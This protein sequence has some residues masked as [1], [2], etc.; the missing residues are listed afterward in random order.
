MAELGHSKFKSIDLRQQ[1]QEQRIQSFN[2]GYHA[3]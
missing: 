3:G 2:K 1:Q